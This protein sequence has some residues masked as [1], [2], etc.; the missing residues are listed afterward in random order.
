M[1]TNIFNFYHQQAIL[2][3]AT[4]FFALFARHDFFAAE[5]AA[6]VC[7]LWLF[8]N[9]YGA[10]SW[11]DCLI[12]CRVVGEFSIFLSFSRIPSASRWF[13]F[14]ATL[15]LLFTLFIVFALQPG[16]KS[17]IWHTFNKFA[18]AWHIFLARF[19]SSTPSLSPLLLL[20]QLAAVWVHIFAVIFCMFHICLADEYMR[21]LT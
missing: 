17:T 5:A 16:H 14:F 2:I 9:L 1:P 4:N 13:F 18:F 11:D 3:K 21:W 15:L 6:D 20:L 12:C 19:P 10:T 8:G 7:Y